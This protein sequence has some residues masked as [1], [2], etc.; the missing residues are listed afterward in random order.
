MVEMCC[1]VAKQ[2]AVSRSIVVSILRSLHSSQSR[3]ARKYGGTAPGGA[4]FFVSCAPSGAHM[5]TFDV[6][7]DITFSLQLPCLLEM[8]K[9]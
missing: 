4:Q 2:L 7:P 3:F 9:T 5:A 1:A 6:A 8:E